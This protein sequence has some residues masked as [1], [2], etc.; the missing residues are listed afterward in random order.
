MPRTEPGAYVLTPV[1]TRELHASIELAL[2]KHEMERKLRQ[3]ERWLAATL[4]S[5]GEAVVATD[6]N[7]RAVFINPV[8]EALTGWKRQE[9]SGQDSGVGLRL[10][11][12]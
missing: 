3:T 11:H 5:I 9:A 1:D 2:Y 6:E 12:P 8:A 10:V 4:K 7:G